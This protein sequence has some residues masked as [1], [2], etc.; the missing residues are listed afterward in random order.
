MVFSPI[1]NDIKEY[2]N[3]SLPP[4]WHIRLAVY[5][6]TKFFFQSNTAQIV[7]YEFNFQVF[8]VANLGGAVVVLTNHTI[9]RLVCLAKSR[10]VDIVDS[11]A[12]PSKV[13]II[14]IL[15]VVFPL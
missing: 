6:A 8:M 1:F 11:N 4:L 5:F 14:V 7:V 9:T 15:H 13:Y 2:N 12:M 3:N 10:V